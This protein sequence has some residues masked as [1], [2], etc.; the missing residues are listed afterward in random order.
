MIGKGDGIGIRGRF[1]ICILGVQIPSFAPVGVG[2]L[3]TPAWFRPKSLEV[4]SL[5]PI[6]NGDVALMVER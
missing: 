6:P 4:R 3:G 2:E 5:P 1:K